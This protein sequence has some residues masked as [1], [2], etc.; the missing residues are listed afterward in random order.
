MS[1]LNKYWQKEQLC[2][3]SN[4]HSQTSED[5]LYEVISHYI[6]GVRQQRQLSEMAA[7]L[8]INAQVSQELTHQ[9]GKIN[10]LAS[11]LKQ[12][13][14]NLFTLNGFPYDNFHAQVVKERVYVPD[15]SMPER[16][17]Y[18]CQLA[19]ILAGCLSSETA[20]GTISTLPL[21][22]RYDWSEQKH[23]LALQALCKAAE[24]FAGI[25]TRTGKSIRLC[26]EMEPD[27]V[28]EATPETIV[29]FQQE[30]P[31]KAE[32]LGID[33]RI[34]E[35]HL[36][37]CFDVCHQAVMFENIQQSMAQLLSA[38]IN[39]GKIQ[40]SSAL[41]VQ[42]PNQEKVQEILK[43][44]AEPKYLHQVR[45]QQDSKVTG[46]L[47]LSAALTDANFPATA[48][49]RIHFHV[50]IQATT[51][52]CQ[53]LKTTQGAILDMLDFLQA[54]PACHPHLE[55]ETY[56]W[57]VLPEVIRPHGQHSLIMGLTEEL[58]WLE[59]AMQQRGL[60]G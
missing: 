38:G 37:I 60:L 18:S 51:L 39:I 3:C 55:V 36:G 13:K 8:W 29:L 52:Q 17:Q 46:Q 27:C 19:D 21:G 40:I 1:V 5:S 31:A 6:N 47:D 24:Y 35:R 53:E 23:S 54:N 26:L 4:V 20:E 15:W 32:Q 22:F 10:K 49:W 43:Q 44:Y 7:G 41:E 2:Y 25:Y 30:L 16:Y 57:H 48:P 58:K 14:I 28:L 42:Y 12:H 45:V 34:I 59:Q 9:P 33:Q 56:T 11:V 50:P